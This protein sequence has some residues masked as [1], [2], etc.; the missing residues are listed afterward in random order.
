MRNF[1]VGT[2]V[3]YFTLGILPNW[4]SNVSFEYIGCFKDD[5]NR[6]LDGHV[7]Y[8]REDLTASVCISVCLRLNFAYAGLQYSYECFCGDSYGKHGPLK[9]SSCSSYCRGN[10]DEMC[11]G[12]WANSIYSLKTEMTTELTLLIFNTPVTRP[13]LAA[14]DTPRSPER[15]SLSSSSSS[16]SYR[17]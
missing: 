4:A 2:M 8:F 17:R 16:S 1:A 3:V 15:K 13:S 7:S 11:G 10:A 12:V 6:D 5:R 14:E 9:E